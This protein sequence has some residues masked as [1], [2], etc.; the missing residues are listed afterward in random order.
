MVNASTLI[1]SNC[2]SKHEDVFV[3]NPV[4]LT[5]NVKSSSTFV[6]GRW[7]GMEGGGGMEIA[8]GRKGVVALAVSKPPQSVIEGNTICESPFSVLIESLKFRNDSAP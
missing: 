7:R 1:P 5:S 8:G 3:T 4:P 6:W 2:L